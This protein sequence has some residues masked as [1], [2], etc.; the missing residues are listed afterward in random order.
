M[1]RFMSAMR[2]L[3]R[4]GQA[5]SPFLFL[6]RILRSA[7]NSDAIP[8]KYRIKLEGKRTRF[9]GIFSEG[10]AKFAY[11]CYRTSMTAFFRREKQRQICT[12]ANPGHSF[13]LKKKN[14]LQGPCRAFFRISR[15]RSLHQLQQGVP[16]GHRRIDA[17][18]GGGIGNGLDLCVEHIL[19][20]FDT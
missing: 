14:A 5:V 10:N 6:R 20:I 13:R 19:E 1:R 9:A 2:L 8:R 11:E 12:C 17:Q 7:G 16:T 18:R 15:V 4:M 3:S